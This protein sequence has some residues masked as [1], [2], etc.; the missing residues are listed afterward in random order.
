MGEDEI[1]EF[2]SFQIQN[3]QTVQDEH[4]VIRDLT[5]TYTPVGY[6]YSFFNCLPKLYIFLHKK[7]EKTCDNQ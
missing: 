1:V 6:D 2:S 4:Y 7:K 3:D 5:L